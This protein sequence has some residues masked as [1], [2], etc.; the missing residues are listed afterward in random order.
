MATSICCRGYAIGTK[1]NLT[2][3]NI[4][5]F[6]FAKTLSKIGKFSV[7]YYSENEKLLLNPEG[8]SDNKGILL[9]WEKVVSEISDKLWF[10]IDYQAG[11]NSFGTVNLGF[12]W[13]FSE[14]TS[15]IF[16]YNIYNNSSIKPTYTVQTDINF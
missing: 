15:V 7:G 16:G 6:K 13:A 14:N 12:S 3:Y 2:N 11:K 5:Y 4:F 9:A 1:A 10:C 8:N